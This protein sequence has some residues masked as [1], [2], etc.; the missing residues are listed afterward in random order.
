L[1][2]NRSFLTAIIGSD[3]QGKHA[4]AYQHIRQY[5]ELSLTHSII[6]IHGNALIQRRKF[7][8]ARRRTVS[9]IRQQ[10][11]LLISRENFVES[12]SARFPELSTSIGRFSTSPALARHP[13]IGQK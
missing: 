11:A 4:T 7:L 9:A 3:R 6:L 13:L 8:C 5:A 10:F 12:D 2:Q 1:R